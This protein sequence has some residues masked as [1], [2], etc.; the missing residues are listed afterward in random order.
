VTYTATLNDKAATRTGRAGFENDVRLEFS[1]NPDSDG[2]GETG[3]TP[4]DTVV[5]FTYQV[6]VTKV[7]N[8]NKTLADAKFRL[9]SDKEC[10][11]EVYVKES[12]NGYIVI[13]RDSLGGT[14]HTGGTAPSTAVEMKSASDGTF[15]ILG[16]DQGTYY[17]LET[18]SPAGYREVLDPIEIVITPT[19]TTARQAYTKGD[20]ATAKTLTNLAAS[21]SGK[22]FFD[23]A[24]QE[25]ANWSNLSANAETGTVSITVI[26]HIGKKLPVTGSNMTL[27]ALAGGSAMMIVG[28]AASKKRKEEEEA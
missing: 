18:D 14:D 7:N 19:F 23:L 1:N 17:L 4:W 3:F 15:K 20:G 21:A 11:K 26:N 9:Y 22:S 8:S 2:T 24:Y 16:L 27:I 12:T 10:T 6:D 28:L 5:A 13:N 25:N